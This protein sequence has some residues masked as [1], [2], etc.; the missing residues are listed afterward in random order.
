MLYKIYKPESISMFIGPLVSIK[1][2]KLFWS[3]MSKSYA[4][5]WPIFVPGSTRVLTGNSIFFCI[6]IYFVTSCFTQI[7]FIK[8]SFSYYN[9]FHFKVMYR[10]LNLLCCKKFYK[11]SSF[12][13][14]FLHLKILFL[15]NVYL[16][17]LTLEKTV[18]QR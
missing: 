5:T 9:F 11:L 8:Q 15:F 12:T 17:K 2:F 18:I 3:T 16:N 14:Y 4:N 1:Y 13:K 10:N 7:I 6:K